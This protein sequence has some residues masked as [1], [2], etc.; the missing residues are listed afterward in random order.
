MKALLIPLITL[1]TGFAYMNT[2]LDHSARYPVP[3]HFSL[4]DT[5]D[6]DQQQALEQLKEEIKGREDSPA[7]EVFANV[8]LFENMA[9]GRLLRV[10][11]MGFSKSLGVTCTHCHNP[12][13]WSSDE[14]IEKEI[15]REMW[16]MTQEI[17]RELIPEVRSLGDRKASVNCTTCHRGDVKPALRLK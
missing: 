14:K 10:M 8:Q 16:A 6:F 1:L 15:A 13:D 7:S 11:E 9:A 17:N 5:S 2:G 3:L 12:A 4:T